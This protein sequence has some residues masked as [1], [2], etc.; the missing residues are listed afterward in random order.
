MPRMQNATSLRL[1]AA[2]IL[3]LGLAACGSSTTAT[4]PPVTNP[5]GTTAQ[6]D[7]GTQAQLASPLPS[8]TGVSTSLGTITI[9]ANGNANTLYSTF[10]QWHLVLQ[11]NFGSTINAGPLSLTTYANGP[12]P[13]ASD[14]YYSSTIG[15]TLTAGTYWS[16]GLAQTGSNCTPYFLGNF[17]T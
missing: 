11:N 5:F 10:A 14:Y 3:T 8:S 13:Y 6:C 7:I 12:K 9:V 4:A 2:G 17:S 15:Q 16:V 1:A